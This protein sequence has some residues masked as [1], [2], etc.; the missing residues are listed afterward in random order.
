[1]R[2][3]TGGEQLLTHGARICANLELLEKGRI[4]G[5]IPIITRSSGSFNNNRGSGWSRWWSSSNNGSCRNCRN[6]S[7]KWRRSRVVGLSDRF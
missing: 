5:I 7:G 2:I 3:E 6:G 4:N 1:M